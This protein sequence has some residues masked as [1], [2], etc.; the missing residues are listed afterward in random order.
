M[1]TKYKFHT[2][3]AL[4]IL[5]LGTAVQA[6]NQTAV[7]QLQ[8]HTQVQ[9]PLQTQAPIPAK[10]EYAAKNFVQFCTQKTMEFLSQENTTPDQKIAAFRELL[11][12]HFDVRT[13]AR[14]ALGRYWKTTTDAQK[15]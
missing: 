11:T 15:T 12:G 14:F 9:T 10:T 6:A 2:L 8:T 4:C 13:M 1:N 3:T 5:S 7:A